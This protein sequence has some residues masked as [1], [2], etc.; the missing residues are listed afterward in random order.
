KSANP[1]NVDEHIS[2]LERNQKRRVC[3][4][5]LTDGLTEIMECEDPHKTISTIATRLSG[6]DKSD[7]AKMSD[8]N[9]ILESY[10]DE[11]ESGEE[12][13]CVKYPYDEWN[14]TTGGIFVGDL[15]V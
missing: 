10:K 11:L 9:E 5:V 3:A 1:N 15:V 8:Y 4:N 12:P 14:E 6:I 2:I 13:K 7:D